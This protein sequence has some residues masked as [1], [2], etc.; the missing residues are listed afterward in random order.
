LFLQQNDGNASTPS[1]GDWCLDA[2]ELKA[3]FN[4]KTKAIIV[5]TPNNPLGKV[6]LVLHVIAL[7]CDFDIAVDKHLQAED[8][9]LLP[10]KKSYSS[11]SRY[12]QFT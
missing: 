6:S 8:S 9:K 4:D 3:M 11:I 12:S 10:M 1:S 7:P 5:N 2:D